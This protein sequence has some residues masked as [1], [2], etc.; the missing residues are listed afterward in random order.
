MRYCRCF[1]NTASRNSFGIQLAAA[2]AVI[3]I[4]SHIASGVASATI[5]LRFYDLPSLERLLTYALLLGIAS[6][7]LLVFGIALM[8][9]EHL[10]Y[11]AENM[12]KRDELTGISN[13]RDFMLQLER[14]HE[15]CRTAA[16]PYSILLIDIDRF[17]HW[18]DNY[19][20]AIGDEALRHFT[21]TAVS[22]L[23]ASELLARTGGD[24]FCLLLPGK[25]EKQAADIATELIKEV[26][27]ASSVSTMNN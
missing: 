20:H 5:G 13:R 4:F 26:R 14:V 19:G 25:A 9:I 27:S 12:A 8:I 15:L 21:R 23:E 24:E 10:L 22:R 3:G 18:N 2:G 17:K 11:E 16:I 1:S 6:A 7:A